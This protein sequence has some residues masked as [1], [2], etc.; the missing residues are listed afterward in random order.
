MS[1][2]ITSLL[3]STLGLVVNNAKNWA[4]KKMRYG[5]VFDQKI[6]EIIE[7]EIE[8]VRS[9]LDALSKKDLLAAID[10][11][12][13][14]ISYLYKAVDLLPG[15]ARRGRKREDEAQ[16]KEA[17]SLLTSSAPVDAI[18]RATGMRNMEPTEFVG[19]ARRALSDGK[20]RFKTAREKATEAFN[21]ESLSTLDRITA[22]RYR[23]MA[24]ILASA[25]EILGT[26]S[27][28]S[29]LSVKSTMKGALPEC[30]QCL[31]KL[32]S[33]PDIENNF[34][35]EVKK[36]LLNIRGRFKKED[37]REIIAAV[38]QVNR[39][40]ND[41][42][43][44]TDETIDICFYPTIDIEDEKIDPRSDQRIAEVLK[45]LSIE[46]ES[47]IVWSFGEDGEDDHKLNNPMGIAINAD[48]EFIIADH[49]ETF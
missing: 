18:V 46:H 41:V 37:R 39:A 49:F 9:K 44:P 36:G 16:L 34:K 23:V 2:I 20:E 19:D 3:E 48:G 26:A 27:E 5:D 15:A 10:T 17:M 29:S 1:L 32:H 38:W 11:L 22:I 8:D 21:N 45:R 13:T 14:G 24:A 30:K 35:V 7:R 12:K 43:Q 25:V 6:R 40:I 42:L 47:F 31:R 4:A 33:L 28:L